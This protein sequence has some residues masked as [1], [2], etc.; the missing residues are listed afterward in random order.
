MMSLIIRLSESLENGKI[1]MKVGDTAKSNEEGVI[2]LHISGYP[3][4]IK[5]IKLNYPPEKIVFYD[6]PKT[7]KT[8]HIVA[9]VL[10]PT[11]GITSMDHELIAL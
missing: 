8:H 3:A 11:T 6:T 10:V 5:T 2:V 1:C 7:G 9:T 4:M